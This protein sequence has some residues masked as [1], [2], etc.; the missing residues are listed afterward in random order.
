MK[1]CQLNK[2]HVSFNFICLTWN[3]DG[4]FQNLPGVIRRTAEFMDKKLSDDEVEELAQHLSFKSMKN[5]PAINGEE[6]IREVK[7][8]HNLPTDDPEL[9]FIRKGEVGSWKQELPDYMIDKFKKWAA[10]KLE[11]T[12]TCINDFI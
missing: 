12:A 6:F 11:G 5:N 1:S 3:Y 4:L 2:M 8:K 9:T 10:E 7:E